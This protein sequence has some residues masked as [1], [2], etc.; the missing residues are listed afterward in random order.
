MENEEG[1]SPTVDQTTSPDNEDA[2]V[3]APKPARKRVAAPTAGNVGA[4]SLRPLSVSS[5]F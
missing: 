4:R 3:P 5:L 2:D 1:T